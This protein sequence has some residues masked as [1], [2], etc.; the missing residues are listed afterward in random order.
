VEEEFERPSGP[1]DVKLKQEIPSKIEIK[2]RT[3]L[4][5]APPAPNVQ[6]ETVQQ[7]EFTTEKLPGAVSFQQQ[8]FKV[9][10]PFGVQDQPVAR[11]A[12]GIAG[13]LSPPPPPNTN[14][15]RETLTREPVE[16][17]INWLINTVWKKRSEQ[18]EPLIKPVTQE[19]VSSITQNAPIPMY[20]ETLTRPAVEKAI[21]WVIN[22]IWSKRSAENQ[23]L[24]NPVSQ[25]E[26]G[27]ALVDI[28]QD[29]FER[30]EGT[31]EV[32]LEESIPSE[33]EI[34]ERTNL[35]IAPPPSIPLHLKNNRFFQAYQRAQQQ[36]QKQAQPQLTQEQEQFRQDI[37]RA[38]PGAIFPDE[39]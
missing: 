31:A 1:V 10:S 11:P 32:K 30:P 20:K 24:T 18:K 13:L 39:K 8:Q 17:A 5:I 2:E 21:N 25:D 35:G 23:P 26:V 36:A 29:E 38:H 9:P 22:S 27:V 19:E 16:K 4:A 6:L 15:Y 3:N 28:P 14:Y 7:D 33:I 34:K 37:R 12:P